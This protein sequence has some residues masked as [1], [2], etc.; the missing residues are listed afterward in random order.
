MFNAVSNES[1]EPSWTLLFGTVSH[2]PLGTRA[3]FRS[4]SRRGE[5]RT[6]RLTTLTHHLS[7]SV[8]SIASVPRMD[9]RVGGAV[10][11]FTSIHL[12]KL[13]AWSILAI[14]EACLKCF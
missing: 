7:L 5:N 3:I 1:S 6:F 8:V 9:G 10:P 11:N 12:H 4:P 14:S 13:T 2:T